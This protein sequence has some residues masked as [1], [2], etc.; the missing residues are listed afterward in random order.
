MQGSLC[1]IF[2]HRIIFNLSSL[3]GSSLECLL[4]ACFLF[5]SKASSFFSCSTFAVSTTLFFTTLLFQTGLF[6]ALAI[7]LLTALLLFATRLFFGFAT[8][9]RGR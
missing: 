6:L 4:L 2:G 3:I 5:G 7:F 9:L 1:G 8:F